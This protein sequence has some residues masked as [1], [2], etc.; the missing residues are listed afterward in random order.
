M[1]H[2]VYH[3]VYQS[4]SGPVLSAPI[5]L[6]D[7]STLKRPAWGCKGLDPLR[8]SAPCPSADPCLSAHSSRDMDARYRS[9]RRKGKGCAPCTPARYSLARRWRVVKLANCHQWKC[10]GHNQRCFWSVSHGAFYFSPPLFMGRDT[11]LSDIFPSVIIGGEKYYYGKETIYGEYL[12]EHHED[13]KQYWAFDTREDLVAFLIMLPNSANSKWLLD[14][15]PDWSKLSSEE[16]SK[17]IS[18][19]KAKLRKL[20]KEKQKTD[21]RLFFP[22]LQC[23]DAEEYYAQKN[24]HWKCADVVVRCEKWETAN[25]TKEWLVTV[26]KGDQYVTEDQPLKF[27]VQQAQKVASHLLRAAEDV[28][29]HQKAAN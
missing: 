12:V 29:K 2:R 15:H 28:E 3:R 22:V 6:I 13:G 18:Q 5:G 8:S 4:L 20:A 16:R 19:R 27:S 17:R 1:C 11:S 9:L 14:Q 21:G 23:D 24:S 10:S 25:E 7:L 26:Y